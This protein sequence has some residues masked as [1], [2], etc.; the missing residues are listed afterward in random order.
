LVP[1]RE[2][3]FVSLDPTSSDFLKLSAN[4][5]FIDKGTDIGYTYYGSHPDLG[6]YEYQ[7]TESS[8]YFVYG[9]VDGD[10]QVTAVDFALLKKYLLGQIDTF[11][12][13]FGEEAADVDGDGQITALD[14]AMMKSYLL[15]KINKFKAEDT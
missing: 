2:S 7:P 4:S 3:D 1:A 6:A 5:R 14:F 11:P 9:D 8:S 10:G 15:G 13:E 12:Y